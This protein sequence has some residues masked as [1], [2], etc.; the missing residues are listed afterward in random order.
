MPLPWRSWLELENSESDW[1]NYIADASR[2]MFMSWKYR[3]FFLAMALAFLALYVG[4]PLF[5]VP[6]NS[7]SLWLGD[8]TPLSLGLMVLTTIGISLLLSMHIYIY[9]CARKVA[10]KEAGVGTLA[11]ITG[12]LSGLLTSATCTVC[13][14]GLLSFIGFPTVLLL[15]Q[16]RIEMAVLSLAI[17]VISLHYTAKRFYIACG[18][19][20]KTKA[21]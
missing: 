11:T 9:R 4:L 3:A 2:Q 10:P 14:G 21:K 12:F 20:T 18:L 8:T 7:L 16:Y 1:M 17:I 15:L 19:K 5:T 13:L 6:G